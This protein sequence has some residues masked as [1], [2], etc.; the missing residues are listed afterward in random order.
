MQPEFPVWWAWTR[1]WQIMTNLWQIYDNCD[2]YLKGGGG[3]GWLDVYCRSSQLMNVKLRAKM[4]FWGC[5]S[6]IRA[7]RAPNDFSNTKSFRCIHED[8]TSDILVKE[9]V[10]SVWNPGIGKMWK[11]S[12]TWKRGAGDRF[13][14]EGAQVCYEVLPVTA[15]VPMEWMQASGQESPCTGLGPTLPG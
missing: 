7:A 12:A 5:C 3:I 6:L 8:P 2:A 14:L 13:G 10:G 15:C 4:V 9:L 11:F 1:S